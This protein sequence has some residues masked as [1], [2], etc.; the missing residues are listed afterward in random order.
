MEKDFQLRF[1]IGESPMVEKYDA[2]RIASDIREIAALPKT[3]A[4]LVKNAS[5]EKLQQ[6]YR[7]GGWSATQVIH[8]I[9]DSHINSFCRF[10][11][12]LTEEN[13]T[14]RPYQEDKWAL[15][16]DYSDAL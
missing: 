10:K 6:T 11:L 7:D 16:N 12:A 1:P 4:A 14:I 5:P 15:L 9:A 13:P 3:L 8:H 2:G